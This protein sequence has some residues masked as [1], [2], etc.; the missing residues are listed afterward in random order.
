MWDI[1]PFFM[2][3]LMRIFRRYHLLFALWALAATVDAGFSASFGHTFVEDVGTITHYEKY[4]DLYHVEGYA[5]LSIDVDLQVYRDRLAKVCGLPHWYHEKVLKKAPMNSFVHVYA[6]KSAI[7]LCQTM[8]DDLDNH[9]TIFDSL[10]AVT[11]RFVVM[12][13]ILAAAFFGAIATYIA[14]SVYSRNQITALDHNQRHLALSAN[15]SDFRSRQNAAHMKMAITIQDY[16]NEHAAHEF[17]RIESWFNVM[18]ALECVFHEARV[19]MDVIN[20]VAVH[21]RFP[22]RLFYNKTLASYLTQ[23]E[24]RAVNEGLRLGVTSPAELYSIP[25]SWLLFSNLTLRIV[26]HIP[27]VNATNKVLYYRTGAP[28]M[29]NESTALTVPEPRYFAEGGGTYATPTPDQLNR[30]IRVTG[31]VRKFLCDDLA[32]YT[33]KRDSCPLALKSNVASRIIDQCDLMTMSRADYWR[34]SQNVF[35]VFL[36]SYDEIR[37]SDGS[38]VVYAASFKGVKRIFVPNNHEL[39]CSYFVASAHLTHDTEALTYVQSTVAVLPIL[40]NYSA[41][42]SISEALQRM[43]PVPVKEIPLEPIPEPVPWYH[44]YLI[45]GLVAVCVIVSVFI[46]CQFFSAWCYS[47]GY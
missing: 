7:R 24:E 44:V 25:I 21:Q 37:I 28:V 18:G 34:L 11:T 41:P 5:D 3:V 23:F 13:T 47:R 36:P 30:C 19:I 46:M 45:Y 31:Q 14:T 32:M 8:V 6:Y 42:T 29:L 1:F 2:T 16:V 22:T 43:K 33:P 38:R 10:K 39:R 27:M 40:Q 35:L 9:I 17:W 15:A 26:A 4:G 20:D 12:A